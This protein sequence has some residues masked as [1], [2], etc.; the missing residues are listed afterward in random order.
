[1]DAS[2]PNIQGEAI[3]HNWVE[4]YQEMEK[5]IPLDIP[6]PKGKLVM[7]TTI[8][9]L[10]IFH[11]QKQGDLSQEFF[12][13][14]RTFLFIGTVKGKTLLRHLLMDLSYLQGGLQQN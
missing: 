3:E 6:S 8:W 13:S 12:C 10:T 11:A 14:S 2:I 9:M 4:L 7:L 5:E 1:M